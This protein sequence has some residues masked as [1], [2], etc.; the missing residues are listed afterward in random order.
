MEWDIR[1]ID[2]GKYVKAILD[3]GHAKIVIIGPNSEGKYWWNLK[4]DEQ[5]LTGSFEDAKRVALHHLNK[6]I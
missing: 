2:N 3:L 6:E 1:N 5:G 4:V